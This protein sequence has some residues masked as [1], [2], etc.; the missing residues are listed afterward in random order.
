MTEPLF[1]LVFVVALRFH[2]TRRVTAGMLLASLLP[3]VRPEGFFLCV[4]WGV[5]VL[6]DRRAPGP[7]WRR[8][9]STL[10]LGAG[11]VV[12][13]LAAL[14]LTG[15]PLFIKHNW[16][17]NWVGAGAIHGRGSFWTYARLGPEIVGPLL[18]VPFAIGL[19]LLVARRRAPEVTSPVLVLFLLHSFMWAH[20]LMGAAGYARYFVCVAPAIAIVMLAGWNAVIGVAKGRVPGVVV[21]AL[22]AIVLLVSAQRAL[23]YV[24]AMPW[25]RDARAHADM[26]DWFRAHPRPVR[27]LAWSK[28]N[29]AVLFDWD[30]WGGLRLTGDRDAKL[31]T[32]RAAP[33]GTL[34]FWD[35][36]AGPANFGLAAT[37]FEAAGFTLL[38]SVS[39]ELERR[40][41]GPP[42][43]RT[44]PESWLRGDLPRHQ[45]LF[46]LYKI[47]DG[48]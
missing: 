8:L 6:L 14:A 40:L 37:D 11:V 28:A 20:G 30:P 47:D 38:R 34:A 17:S 25:S 31:A 44:R 36:D 43:R 3:L 2:L 48:R 26:F 18:Q 4:L 7:W 15:D 27:Q 24:D 23:A 13:W 21:H 32:L 5:W 12:W 19:V 9:P 46:L 22:A 41:P 33:A 35:D 45:R 1:A 39:Y 16:P 42:W 10:W 29:M